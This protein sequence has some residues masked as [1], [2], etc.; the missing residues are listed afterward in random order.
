MRKRDL[1]QS[2]D[3]L[4]LALRKARED[5]G[6]TCIDLEVRAG[7]Q[8]GYL[9]KLENH[10][11]GNKNKT[12]RG[13]GPLTFGLWLQSLGVSL[14]IVTDASEGSLPR[15]HRPD[16]QRASGAKGGLARAAKLTKRQHQKEMFRLSRLRKL[17]LTPAER[18]LSASHAAKA[19]WAKPEIQ[20]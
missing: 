13:I 11:T 4:V 2:Y 5:A 17:R 12:T 20:P 19:R 16:I 3:D 14:A 7:F 10:T 18:S 6:L 1:I 8:D 15:T 9:S